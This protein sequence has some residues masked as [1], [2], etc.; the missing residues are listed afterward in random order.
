MGVI[1]SKLVHDLKYQAPQHPNTRPALEAAM[2]EYAATSGA[3]YESEYAQR[4]FDVGLTL[5]CAYYPTHPFAV[6]LHIAIY[7]WLAIYIDDD[8]AGNDDLAGF[9]ERFHRGEPQPSA[10]LSRFAEVLHD[11]SKYYE[12]L[13]A[14]F[15]VCST[16]Q[17]VNATLLER[18]G[19]FHG[20]KHCK[21][22]AAGPTM[23][24]TGVECPRRI[25][26]MM[27]YINYANDILSFHKETLAGE[28]DNYINTRA[29]CEQRE[30][31]AVLETVV[32]E[33]IEANSRVVGLL[34]TRSDPMY[35]LK[36]DEFF[37]G[38]IFFHLSAKRYKLHVYPGL[39]HEGVKELVDEGV[40]G[41]AE[42]VKGLEEFGCQR[43]GDMEKPAVGVLQCA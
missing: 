11:M 22:Q 25:P 40:S 26:D 38:Y 30:P 39:A 7:S 10:L 34:R 8:D 12:P 37:N 14:N 18:R 9:Q 36:W 29:V 42:A 13:V 15:I 20:L 43:A 35:A 21:R 23:S 3:P 27:T 6:K 1:F 19:E 5:A 31:L 28:T 16:L 33:A 4:Y 17:F 2:L 32:A 24:A 41:L